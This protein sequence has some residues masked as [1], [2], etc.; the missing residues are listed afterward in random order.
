M[1][2][3][4]DAAGPAGL[5]IAGTDNEDNPDSSPEVIASTS[6]DESESARTDSHGDV[7]EFSPRTKQRLFYENSRGYPYYIRPNRAFG[8]SGDDTEPQIVPWSPGNNRRY[9]THQRGGR[10]RGREEYPANPHAPRS[11][12]P[13]PAERRKLKSQDSKEEDDND[14]DESPASSHPSRTPSPRPATRIETRS[15][16]FEDLAKLTEQSKGKD[17]GDEDDDEYFN[18]LLGSGDSTRVSTPDPD[19]DLDLD[20]TPDHKTD[21]EEDIEEAES[22]ERLGDRMSMK[23]PASVDDY[24]SDIEEAPPSPSS[25][26]ML[27]SCTGITVEEGAR[28]VKEENE[29]QRGRTTRPTGQ[30]YLNMMKSII[31]FYHE[32]QDVDRMRHQG[33][34][35]HHS[36]TI[37]EDPEERNRCSRLMAHRYRLL[38]D[39]T[40]FN[41][42]KLRDAWRDDKMELDDVKGKLATQ[43][44]RYVNL[45]TSRIPSDQSNTELLKRLT[46]VEK[47][48]AD[49]LE[50]EEEQRIRSEEYKERANKVGR[51]LK[52]YKDWAE[53]NNSLAE[54]ERR[55]Q[56]LESY[57]PSSLEVTLFNDLDTLTF[58]T[59]VKSAHKRA[60]HSLPS[61]QLRIRISLRR[62]ICGLSIFGRRPSHTVL[63]GSTTTLNGITT[64]R[65]VFRPLNP[66]DRHN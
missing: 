28:M 29:R 37:P 46:G 5:G 63:V 60:A 10:A 12:S 43:E 38:R 59:V 62:R 32:V 48:L 26:E 61:D 66:C 30:E 35:K 47:Q 54:R 20:A 51:Q 13:L 36:R 17:W 24:S 14:G 6:V 40:L 19:P 34:P 55:R 42:G 57:V 8:T 25:V 52:M 41:Y 31:T 15:T 56:E 16:S 3:E 18:S 44:E 65:M 1:S 49:A 9:H 27:E 11:P 23:K 58:T 7:E 21:Q 33:T 22:L 50:H 64:A 4:G 45:V 53:A 2:L 39:D